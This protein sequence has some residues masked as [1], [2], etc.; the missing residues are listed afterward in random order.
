M[1][2]LNKYRHVC[3]QY[4]LSR[5]KYFNEPADELLDASYRR[6]TGLPKRPVDDD[7]FN[8]L[9]G[10]KPVIE[11][12][13]EILNLMKEGL[14]NRK[15]VLEQ[16]LHLDN[17]VRYINKLKKR[18]S[19]VPYVDLFRIDNVVVEEEKKGPSKDI[20]SFKTNQAAIDLM[21]KYEGYRECTYKDPGSA[22]GLP[23]TGGY[24]STRLNGKKLQLGQCYSKEIWTNQF[25]QDLVVFEDAVKRHV[26]VPLTLD[27]FSALV[28]F[29]YNCGE[30][31][32]MTSTGLKRLNEGNYRGC[33][34][35]LSWFKKGANG[36]TLP[37]LVKRRQAEAKLAGFDI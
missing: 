25:K 29:C 33:W 21:H 9:L 19:K 15:E 7:Q 35:A 20:S 22:S 12:R 11:Q 23:I 10:H 32:L 14:R 28:S 27:Q 30:A 1:N 13:T 31:A 18:T 5:V 3:I 2:N 4:L 26:K 37:G 17:I 36:Q 24:G 6:L 34:V 8:G 16:D